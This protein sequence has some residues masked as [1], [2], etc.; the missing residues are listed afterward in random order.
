M[1]AGL[2]AALNMRAGVMDK[3]WSALGCFFNEF[4]CLNQYPDWDID[5][6]AD[7]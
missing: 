2:N 6:G 7:R 5:S 1:S 4:G 3:R